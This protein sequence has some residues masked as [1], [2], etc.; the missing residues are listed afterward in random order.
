[1]ALVT[2]SDGKETVG[3]I[4]AIRN[5]F[6]EAGGGALVCLDCTLGYDHGHGANAQ[7]LTFSGRWA[8]DGTPFRAEQIVPPGEMP[9][10]HARAAARE[11]LA[12]RAAGSA[13][14]AVSV[15]SPPIVQDHKEQG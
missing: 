15:P 2:D 7:V 6:K 3:G 1:M 8:V 5:A 4:V 9:A 11:L 12:G 10:P 14:P 13:Q